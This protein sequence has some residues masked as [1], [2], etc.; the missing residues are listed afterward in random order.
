MTNK[1]RILLSITLLI[2]AVGFVSWLILSQPGEPVYHGKPLSYWCD[3]YAENYAPVPNMAPVKQAEIA[4]RTIGTNGVPTLLRL[5]KAKDS[6][7]KTKFIQFAQKQHVITVKWEPASLKNGQALVGFSILGPLGKSAVPAL[8]EIYNEHR[9]GPWG[10]SDGIAEIFA[11]MGPA[12]AEA[13][14]QL[15]QDTANANL[16]IRFRAVRA[17]RQIHARP[18][19]AVPALTRALLDQDYGV[20]TDAALSLGEFGTDATSAV[21]E[22]IKA[23]GDPSSVVRDQAAS[24]LKKIDPEAAAQAGVK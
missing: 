4:I 3:Q 6:K 24:A 13:V 16:F 15:S 7:F 2:A 17:L 23:L 9:N 10:Q 18:G 14:P 19:L 5:L 21:P 22:L 20:R 12:A 11:S 8:L 1:R